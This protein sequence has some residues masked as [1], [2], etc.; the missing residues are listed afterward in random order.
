MPRL[1]TLMIA[2]LEQKLASFGK[3]RPTRI[4]L[5]PQDTKSTVS[6]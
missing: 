2:D 5:S 4:D 1:T 3:L 6:E